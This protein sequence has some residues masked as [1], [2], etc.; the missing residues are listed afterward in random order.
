MLLFILCWP[1]LV[2]FMLVVLRPHCAV[3]SCEVISHSLLPP[4]S[5]LSDHL[6]VSLTSLSSVSFVT[7]PYQISVFFSLSHKDK[8]RKQTSAKRKT[9]RNT[10][11][12]MQADHEYRNF[13]FYFLKHSSRFWQHIIM[14]YH[15]I[16]WFELI[17]FSCCLSLSAGSIN[18]MS[19]HFSPWCR[20]PASY[21]AW[22]EHQRCRA[23]VIRAH[24]L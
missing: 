10:R 5:P 7:P 23:Q 24:I 2:A 3:S 17:H 20:P 6:W 13:I 18:N 19:L 4:S 1:G 14:I 9:K 12:K 16:H 21:C 11:K 8:V 15:Q 22:K